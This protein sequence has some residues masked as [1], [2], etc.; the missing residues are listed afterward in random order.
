MSSSLLIRHPADYSKV[1][2]LFS[3]NRA[4]GHP[5][6]LYVPPFYRI[7]RICLVKTFFLVKQKWPIPVCRKL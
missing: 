5:E 6:F 1:R 3:V 4:R 7:F 2:L